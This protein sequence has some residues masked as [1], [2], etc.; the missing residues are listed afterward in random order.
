M[1]EVSGTSGNKTQLHSVFYCIVNY[2]ANVKN[3]SMRHLYVI[4]RK[5]LHEKIVQIN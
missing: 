3:N 1:E 4:F 5:A 2:T